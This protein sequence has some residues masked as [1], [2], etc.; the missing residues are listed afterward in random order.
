MIMMPIFSLFLL[1]IMSLS[2][3]RMEKI[4]LMI[5]EM[6]KCCGVMIM[7][8]SVEPKENNDDDKPEEITS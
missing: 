5:E 6:P 1:I 4:K 7:C 3:I 8:I 2:A